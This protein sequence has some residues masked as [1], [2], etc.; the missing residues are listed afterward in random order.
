MLSMVASVSEM[1]GVL[2]PCFGMKIFLFVLIIGKGV[3]KW[4]HLQGGGGREE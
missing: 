1:Q 2:D 3:G 4:C